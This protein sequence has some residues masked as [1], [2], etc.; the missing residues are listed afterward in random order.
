[1]E[2]AGQPQT[3]PAS[4]RPTLPRRLI[5]GD[6][7]VLGV[8]LLFALILRTYRMNAVPVE[9]LSWRDTLNLMVARNFLRGGMNLFLPE[10]DF[11][12]AG[13]WSDSG[14]IGGTELMIVPWLT[15][16]LYH[17]FGQ[18]FWVGRLAPIGFSLLGLAFFHRLAARIHG[19]TTAAIATA[20]LAVSPY[21]LFCGRCQMAEPFVY[22]MSYGAL[23]AYDRWLDRR[24]RGAF[25]GAVA[26]TCLMM[27]GKPQL[28]VMAIPL[29]FLTFERLGPR[30]F[31]TGSV[32]VFGGIVAATT[33]LYAWWS[34][35]VL[36]QATGIN[37][38]GEGWYFDHGR[39]LL[40]PRYYLR[41]GHALWAL[42]LTPL[43]CIG[44][45]VGLALP[46]RDRRQR[47]A[48]AWLAGG[49]ALFLLIPGGAETNGYYQLILAAPACLL[50]AHALARLAAMRRPTGV[51]VAA[52]LTAI[53]MAHS[54]YTALP[55]YAPRDIA[56]YRCGRW[57]AEHTP[58]DAV[59][60]ASDQNTATLYFADRRGWTSWPKSYGIQ[61]AFDLDFVQRHGE[62][63]ATVL[64]IPHARFDDGRHED[65]ADVRDA[66][67]DSFACHKGAGYTVF[68]LDRRP[69]LTLPGSSV[70][71]GHRDARRYLRG[72][73]GLDTV[74]ANGVPCTP[75]GPVSGAMI[76]F[77]AATPVRAIEVTLRS[78]VDDQEV[79]VWV[80][81]EQ[82]A[83][84]T[85]DGSDTPQVVRIAPAP[86]PDADGMYTVTLRPSRY[87]ARGVGLVLYAIA[88]EP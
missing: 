43:V 42:G 65:Y 70:A 74:D 68:F 49:V 20:L 18:A 79:A 67:Y 19:R 61:P 39:W 48:H 82:A 45:L 16:A 64:A 34:F 73:W 35:G 72:R 60:I 31:R 13:A 33:A 3:E 46:V 56:L 32:Y 7:L 80:Q 1:M 85:M 25:R 50:T 6:A 30:T 57:I 88:T 26:L 27:L 24:S 78:V 75:M 22:A 12:M 9:F 44:G 83:S 63:G 11:R 17:V 86:P 52:G 87:D 15:A 77:G 59:M 5:G 40:S 71:F 51:W 41:I 66:L 23:W 47:L 21:Y 14:V 81:R 38:S 37:L 28:A 8:I 76:R 36:M 62:L 54:V 53:A 4:G 55:M 69:D 10:V 29:G 84:V 58:E 2:E